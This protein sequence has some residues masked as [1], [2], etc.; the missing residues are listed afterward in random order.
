MFEIT[1]KEQLLKNVRKGLVQ[2]LPNQY[3]LLNFEKDI[4][5]RQLLPND[6]SF[7]KKWVHTG[8][9]F[10]TF[11][12]NYDLVHQIQ[13][14]ASQYQLGQMAI[15]EKPLMELFS[16]N[17]IPYLGIENMDKTILC[18]FSK[19]ENTTN[20]ICFSSEVHPVKY[21]HRASHI[22]LYGRSSQVDDPE[23]NHFYS[24]VFMKNELRIQLDI[25]YF[26]RF[27]SVFLFLDENA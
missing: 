3:P 5:K 11:R 21:F 4:L 18:G 19:L 20:G 25:S 2:P 27:K 1:P 8:F 6:E 16:D 17:D 15:Q 23:N 12:G 24:E 13:S 7:V 14:T 26:K 9:L 10:Q 22:V